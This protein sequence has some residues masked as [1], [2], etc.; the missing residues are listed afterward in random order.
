MRFGPFGPLWNHFRQKP[1][2]TPGQG[3]RIFTRLRSST[4]TAA[5]VKA[6]AATNETPRRVYPGRGAEAPSSGTEGWRFA[7]HSQTANTARAEQCSPRP[8]PVAAPQARQIDSA[9]TEKRAGD[10]QRKR[11]VPERDGYRIAGIGGHQQVGWLTARLIFSMEM[12]PTSTPKS[13]MATNSRL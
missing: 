11:H 3:S 12:N 4:S 5:M 7:P 13:P 2:C 1:L 9:D 6:K 8:A 10:E